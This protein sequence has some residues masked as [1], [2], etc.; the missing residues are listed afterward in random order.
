[1]PPLGVHELYGR[2]VEVDERAWEAGDI[3]EDDKGPGEPVE[4]GKKKAAAAP[5]KKK[6]E[7]G[8]EKPKRVRKPKVCGL[9]SPTNLLAGA[10]GLGFAAGAWW[11][12]D[13]ALT[14]GFFPCVCVEGRRGRN[15]RG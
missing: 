2:D 3:P 14:C 6:D 13:W 15:G 10:G 11:A 9:S 7:D 8:A 4:T 5:R 12:H 1:M